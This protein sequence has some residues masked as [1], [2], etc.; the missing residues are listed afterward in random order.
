ME[1]YETCDIAESATEGTCT[2][3]SLFDLTM[4]EYLG[5][6]F[7]MVI[8]FLVNS[9]G[10]SGGGVI[11]PT[12]AAFFNVNTVHSIAMSNFSIFVSGL[13]RIIINFNVRHPLKNW[14][15]LVDYNVVSIMMPFCII[16]SAVGIILN[17][18]IPSMAVIVI[19]EVIILGV[20]ITS[21]QKM[22]LLHKNEKVYARAQEKGKQRR[23]S[24]IRIEHKEKP[25]LPDN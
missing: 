2:H 16:G 9:G 21:V 25:H 6:Y 18:I 1:K 17:P 15:T 22:V 12:A 4:L 10:L 14:A 8:I 23:Q 13:I 7:V 5:S 19:M 24:S 11:M 3:K 20:L